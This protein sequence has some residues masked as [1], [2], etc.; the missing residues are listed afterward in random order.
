MKRVAILQ[1]N[2]IPWKGYFDLI[3]MV[4]EFVF[5]DEVQ[6]T[7]NDWRNRN[8]IKTVQGARWLTIPVSHSSSQRIDETKCTD[9]NWRKKHWASISQSYAR[10]AHFKVFAPCFEPLYLQSEEVLLSRINYAFIATINDIL[11]IKTKVSWSSDYHIIVGKTERLVDICRKT[12]ATEYLS[13][14]AA[15]GYLNEGAFKEAEIGVKWMDYSD[16]K[17]YAQIF[18]PFDHFVSVLDLIFNEGPNAS[19]FL[20]SKEHP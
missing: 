6:Y 7:K 14:P 4:D 3:N 9:Q 16:Y 5:L 19:H 10:A 15:K 8:R 17:E 13:G 20:K 12:G 1:S 11:E 2:Y 18:P